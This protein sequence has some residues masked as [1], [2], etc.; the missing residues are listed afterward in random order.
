MNNLIPYLQKGDKVR[1]VSPAKSIEPSI[2]LEAKQL[3]EEKGFKV[4]LGMNCLGSKNY[5][6]GSDEERLVDF[7]EAL[8]DPETKAI[9]CNRGGYGCVRI[10]DSLDWS[11]FHKNP[12]WIV[13]FS[14]VTV[15]HQ[16][17]QR[18]NYPSL[19][20]TMPLNY[21]TNSELAI[22]SFI[23]SL[24]GKSQGFKLNTAKNSRIGE[25]QGELIGGNLSIVFSLLGTNGQPNFENKIL[26][27][28]D[29]SEQL[30][31]IDRM[32]ITLK[33]AG[34]F[35]GIK[36]LIIGSFTDLKDT[37]VPFGQSI[38]KIFSEHVSDHNFPIVFDFPAGHIDDNRALIF[39]KKANL[40]VEE[41]FTTLDYIMSN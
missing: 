11:N 23:D 32:L 33:K 27:L 39:G 36:G 38:E 34:I 15:F 10:I 3:L 13:G 18:N 2:V 4:E 8:D 30:Y 17:L 20:A 16:Y 29:L 40:K 5:F 31:H 9:I 25:A 12:K 28:E 1:L 37:E 24:S 7:Q 19:H 41:N 21:A 22:D 26:F 6:S 35:K 14:D